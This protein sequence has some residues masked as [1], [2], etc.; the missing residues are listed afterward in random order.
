MERYSNIPCD[1]LKVG[2]HGSKTS[3]SD[4]FVKYLSPKEAII[5]CGKNNKYGHPHESVLRILK[6]NNITI[7]RTDIL[8]T[9]T[10]SNYKSL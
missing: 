1:I 6:N 2:H 10:Y 7:R 8:G 9:I 3:T 5:S 4:T